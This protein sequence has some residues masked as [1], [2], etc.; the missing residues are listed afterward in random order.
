MISSVR[1]TRS[2]GRLFDVPPAT[3]Q[4][5]RPSAGQKRGAR[6]TRVRRWSSRLQQGPARTLLHEMQ[7]NRHQED[8]V[9]KLGTSP[10]AAPAFP[11]LPAYYVPF[12]RPTR[13][14]YMP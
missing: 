6:G 8:N 13:W 3:R 9:S 7:E 4:S 11:A 12:R 14:I 1:E 2:T 10:P 5:P